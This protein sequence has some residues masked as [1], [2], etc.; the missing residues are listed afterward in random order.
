MVFFISIEI[1]DGKKLIVF[2]LGHAQTVYAL[3]INTV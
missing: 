3:F 2:F 1:M